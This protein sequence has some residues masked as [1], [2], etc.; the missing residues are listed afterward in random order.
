MSKLLMLKDQLKRIEQ[1][2][3]SAPEDT[4]EVVIS[5]L[6][7]L[8]IIRTELLQKIQKYQ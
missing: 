7:E 8:R 2:I 3:A 4:D 6:R 5:L 1:H